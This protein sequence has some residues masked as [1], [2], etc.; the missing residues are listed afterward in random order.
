MRN[1][2]NYHNK[3]LAILGAAFGIGSAVLALAANH[4][5][6]VKNKDINGLVPIEAVVLEETVTIK[7]TSVSQHPDHERMVAVEWTVD[8]Q[9][10]SKSFP[11]EGYFYEV[12]YPAKV[13]YDPK[14]PE[15]AMSYTERKRSQVLEAFSGLFAF[16]GVVSVLG[17]LTPVKSKQLVDLVAKEGKK[18]TELPPMVKKNMEKWGSLAERT[19]WKK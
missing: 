10:Y 14:N 8:S 7:K 16:A 9:T 17:G 12:G 6:R 5:D 11:D 2:I 3:D 15:Y 4:V 18:L 19:P 13:L 1:K